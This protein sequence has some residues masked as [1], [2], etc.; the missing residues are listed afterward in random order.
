LHEHCQ[1]RRRCCL[2]EVSCPA[3]FPGLQIEQSLLNV[4]RECKRHGYYPMM[5]GLDTVVT[6][7]DSTGA[8]LAEPN[9]KV[10]VTPYGR[11]CY[12]A[13]Q[14]VPII[15]TTDSADSEIAAGKSRIPGA[16]IITDASPPSRP[17]SPAVH[18]CWAR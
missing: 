13:H 5:N 11:I 4:H 1:Y 9:I 7:K 12:G 8:C 6:A 18:F 15:S 3:L 16:T 17:G 10:A 14:V 2:L